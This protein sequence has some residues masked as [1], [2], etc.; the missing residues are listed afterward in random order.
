[1]RLAGAATVAT[2]VGGIFLMIRR[3][4]NSV[5]SAQ[6]AKQQNGGTAA[7]TSNG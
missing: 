5:T 6:S 7:A 2:L 4:R 3:D 1:M